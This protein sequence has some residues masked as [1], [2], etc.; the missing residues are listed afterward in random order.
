L[1]PGDLVEVDTV[2]VRPVPGVVFKQ[3]TARDVVSRWDVIQA[4]TRATAFTTTEFLDT[5]QHRMPFPIRAVQV[6]GGSEFAAEFEQAC[7]QRGLHLFVL[8]PRSPKL[9]GAVERAN[10]THT[11]EFY[12]VTACS[13]EMKKLNRELRQW[14]RIYNTVRPHQVLGVQRRAED[15]A[16]LIRETFLRGIS[17]RQV[18][19]V[20]ATLTGEVVS[21]QTVSKLT[22]D[23]DD[24]VKQFHQARLSDDYAYLFLDGVSLRVRR[25]AGRKRVHMLVAYGVRRDGTRHLLA[26]MRS[27]GESQADWEGLLGDLYRRGLEGKQLGLIVTD[28]CAGLA[29]AIPTVYPRVRHQR[30]WVHKMRNILEKVQKRDYD[31]VKTGAQ[32]I[33]LADGA[34][35]ATRSPGTPFGLR[36][37]PSLVAEA[38]HHQ[39]N[40]AL[41][42]RSAPPNP[43]HGVLCE[44]RKRRPYH[45]LHLPAI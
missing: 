22:R 2:D 34:T 11:E 1:E 38:A 21:A 36:L 44:C 12:Q 28:G 43:P 17:T 10:H 37:S 42:R 8:P 6:D 5:L 7:R 23:L 40:R 13:L 15:I 16:M 30:C 32:A 31:E 27:Q 39:C 14:E 33:Y 4:H 3:F 20:V 24:A 25:P 29:A 18:G 41:L 45:L 26:F 9:N 35:T 19:R